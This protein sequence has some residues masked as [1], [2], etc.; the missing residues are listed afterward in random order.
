M[1]KSYNR[2]KFELRGCGCHRNQFSNR[3]YL[4]ADAKK[5]AGSAVA[6]Q[7]SNFR[8]SIFGVA[9]RTFIEVPKWGY[10]ARITKGMGNFLGAVRV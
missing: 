2:R 5:K 8:V 3:S 1:W 9:N 6:G 4:A 7:N 10:G